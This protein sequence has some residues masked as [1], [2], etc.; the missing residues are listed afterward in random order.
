MNVLITGAL[1]HIGSKILSRLNEVNNIKNVYIIDNLRSNNINVLFNLNPKKI[2]IKFIRADLINYKILNNIKI[3][4]DVVIHLA[5][6]TNM[7]ESFK[8]KEIIFENN[9]RIFKNIVSFCIKKKSKLVHLSSTSVYGYQSKLADE[10][11]NNLM[12][13][14]PYAEEKVLEENYLKKKLKKL[15]FVTLRLGT[16]TGISKGMRFHTAVN[17]FCLN[18]I[19]NDYIPVWGSAMNLY[20][21]Y[22]SLNDAVKTIFFFINNRKFNN[23][24]YNIISSNYTVKEILDII[25]SFNF[26]PKIKVVKSPI[27]NQKSFK[28]SRKKID[29]TGLKLKGDIVNDIK[30]TLKMLIGINQINNN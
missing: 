26:K 23:Q 22:L 19:L 13:Q 2:K 27:L 11:S 14:S 30:S 16:I 1:G 25:R 29:M 15:K 10:N 21:P 3:K 28:V 6:I 9:Y 18:A 12:P 7:E 20:R 8:M 24:I 5:S 4:I 17:K